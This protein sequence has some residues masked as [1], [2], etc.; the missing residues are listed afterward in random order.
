MITQIVELV[1]VPLVGILVKFLVDYLAAKRDEL[2]AYTSNATQRKYLD[3]ITDTV[4]RCVLA[5]NQ[6]YV[7]S[8]KAQGSFD[9]DAQEEAFDRTL[10]AVTCILSEEAKRYLQ[11]VYGDVD[12][13]LTQLIEAQV[14]REKKEFLK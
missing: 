8:L 1:L 5:T 10:S 4:T 6:T 12:I 13:Y 14:A 7:N 11:E 2:K 3:M 9:A